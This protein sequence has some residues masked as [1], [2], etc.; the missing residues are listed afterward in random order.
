MIPA[1]E[2]IELMIYPAF[3]ARA[4]LE[5]LDLR[6]TL[7][8]SPSSP[9]LQI[10][11][12]NKPPLFFSP[13]ATNLLEHELSFDNINRGPRETYFNLQMPREVIAELLG[14]FPQ[15]LDWKECVKSFEDEKSETE[16]LRAVYTFDQ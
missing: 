9:Y 15:R 12:Q 14:V 4:E 3:K 6:N 11:V 2:D 1:P 7:P 13:K 16:A 10:R 5:N 8:D